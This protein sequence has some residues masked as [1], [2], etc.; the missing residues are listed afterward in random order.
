M[1]AVVPPRADVARD[2]TWDLEAMFP[3]D[4]AWDAAYQ[5]AEA[6]LAT[7]KPFAGSLH[8]SA[9]QLLAALHAK[10]AIEEGLAQV[11]V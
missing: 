11:L 6:S 9:S 10:D 1:S 7:M 2:E 8:V 5:A 3:S 4:A